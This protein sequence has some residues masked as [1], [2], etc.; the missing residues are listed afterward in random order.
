MRVVGSVS[1]LTTMLVTDGSF[2]GGKLE[3]AR[4]LGTR[5]VDPETYSLL[6]KNLQPAPVPALPN[7]VPKATMRAGTG[8]SAIAASPSEIRAWGI[9]NGY[10]VGARGRLHKELVE[11]YERA[12]LISATHA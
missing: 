1:G 4:E 8:R 11:A 5:V 9:A 2:V 12:E 6:L 7:S 3:R 10:M